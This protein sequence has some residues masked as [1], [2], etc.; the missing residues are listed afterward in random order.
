VAVTNSRMGEI[1]G[2]TFN[3]IIKEKERGLNILL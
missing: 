2:A 1:A 3:D